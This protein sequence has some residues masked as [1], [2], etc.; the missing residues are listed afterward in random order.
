MQ[1]YFRSN[2]ASIRLSGEWEHVLDVVIPTDFSATNFLSMPE[3]STML[4]VVTGWIR[5]GHYVT[6]TYLQESVSL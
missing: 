1:S 3:E 2:Y 4:R 5:E 6:F